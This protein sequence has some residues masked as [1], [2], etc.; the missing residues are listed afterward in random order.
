VERERLRVTLKSVE[1]YNEFFTGD[2]FDRLFQELIGDKFQITRIMA[3][4]REK[5]R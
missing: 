1:E 3:L 4:L 5:P 2:E